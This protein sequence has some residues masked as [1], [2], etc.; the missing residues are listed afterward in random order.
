ME[1]AALIPALLTLR[2]AAERFGTGQVLDWGMSDSR[3]EHVF[4]L[5][6]WK[7]PASKVGWRA[8]VVH[9]GSGSS[10][11]TTECR[12]IVDFVALRVAAG[13]ERISCDKKIG[14]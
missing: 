11:A 5:R 13:E 9:L 1:S 4:V 12:D 6:V 2:G 14:A 7:E 8:S 10:V 3:E